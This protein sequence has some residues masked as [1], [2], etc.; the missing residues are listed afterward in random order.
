MLTLLRRL[1]S[2]K[3]TPKSI[4]PSPAS[5]E[6]KAILKEADRMIS[7]VNAEIAES[8][9]RQRHQDAIYARASMRRVK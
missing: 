5:L 6:M 9:R 2:S 4:G 8:A 7:Q 3:P 1:I